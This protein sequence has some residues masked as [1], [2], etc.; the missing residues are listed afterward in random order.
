MKKAIFILVVG[1]L[2]ATLYSCSPSE[3]E[4]VNPVNATI[5]EDGEVIDDGEGREGDTVGEDGEV[6]DDGEGRY[7]SIL[8]GKK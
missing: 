8:Q 7:S 2:S 4:V 5:G 3:L 1:V 6:I